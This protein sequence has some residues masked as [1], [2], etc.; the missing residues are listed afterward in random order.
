MYFK[1]DRNNVWEV[2]VAAMIE[3]DR[4]G[5]LLTFQP[6]FQIT[7]SMLRHLQDFIY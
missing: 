5:I 1:T 6:A 3:F 7:E 2:L 4:L